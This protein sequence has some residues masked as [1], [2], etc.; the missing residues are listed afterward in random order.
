[1]KSCASLTQTEEKETQFLRIMLWDLAQSK[2]QVD[3]N[4]VER[5]QTAEGEGETQRRRQGMFGMWWVEASY[6]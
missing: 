1:M 5:Q 3:I 6:E 2:L 4:I